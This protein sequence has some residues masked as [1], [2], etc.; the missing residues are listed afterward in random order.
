MDIRKT[1][2]KGR[3]SLGIPSKM[4]QIIRGENGTIVLYPVTLV[5]KG[6]FPKALQKLA[7]AAN[8][9]YEA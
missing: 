2:S 9:H 3:L 4:Y 7:T 5:A 8:T 1:D 6:E